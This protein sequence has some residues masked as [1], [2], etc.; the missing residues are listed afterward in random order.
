MSNPL[1]AS[2]I[3][4]TGRRFVYDP[5]SIGGARYW[6]RQAELPGSELVEFTT[7]AGRTYALLVEL[8]TGCCYAVAL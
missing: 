5:A 2:G 7:V 4:T 8:R 1:P 6:V 3:G